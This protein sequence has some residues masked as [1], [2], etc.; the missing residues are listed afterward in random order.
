M[1][2]TLLA[3]HVT[4]ALLL[5][6]LLGVQCGEL[7][8]LRRAPV[9]QTPKRVLVAVVAILPVTLFVAATGGRLLS[10]GSHVGAWAIAGMVSSTLIFI[11]ALNAAWVLGRR[12]GDRTVAI[13][14]AAAVTIAAAQW[15][16]P[17]FT[18]AGAYLM[19]ARPSEVAPAFAPIALAVAV[20]IAM[21]MRAKTIRFQ[22]A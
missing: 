17:A 11:T 18:L 12:R 5:A 4:A 15:G 22:P 13:G 14:V 9:T 6:V 16:T 10:S 20:T 7:S 21:C 3:T 8:R 1:S 2:T 19:A